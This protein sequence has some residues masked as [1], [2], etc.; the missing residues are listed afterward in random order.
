MRRQRIV[1]LGAAGRDFHNFNVCFR[2][3]A[4]YKVVAFTAA[5][6]PGITDRRYPP[7][8]SGALYP[9]GIPIR[10][11]A[12]IE[13]LIQECDVH[14]V[15]LAYSDLHH[16]EVM[17]LASRALAA[18]ADFVLL[19][20]ER[21][22]LRATKPVIAVC[23]TRTGCGK[24]PT[25]R[26]I[27]RVLRGIGLRVVVVRHP[28]PYGDL[29]RERVQRFATLAEIDAASPTIEEREEYESWVAEGVVVYAGVD[30]Q[31]ILDRAQEEADV[32][33]WDGGNNDFPFYRPDLWI[34]VADAHRPGHETCYHPG[35][36]NFRAAD[37]VLIHKVNTAPPQAVAAIRANAA[38]LNPEARVL[39]AAIEVT[40]EDPDAIRGKRVL[41]IE[42][43]PTLTHGGLTYGAGKVAAEQ[44]GARR[45]VDPRPGAVGSIREVFATYP[46]LGHAIPAMGYSP[47]QLRD[48]EQTI[49]RTRCDT[50]VIATPIDLRRVV[51]I[52]R[53]A[54]RVRYELA[55]VEPEAI[56]EAIRVFAVRYESGE[57]A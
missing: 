30:Y 52:D 3:D 10:P 47:E 31:A 12:K 40:A 39:L 17:H 33:L 18:G 25:C 5:Q 22:M 45:I 26:Y 34:T 41:L 37:I 19:G 57:T 46:H 16:L 24:S 55:E 50:V 54:T 35:E 44:Y 28:M 42:D 13:G 14:Q 56:A 51:K 21:T 7:E 20:P 48:L 53:P 23:A 15:V 38:R 27:A 29:L 49:N 36:T 1:I 6:I 32:L 43:G 2:D 4:S 8:L 11:E 9:D